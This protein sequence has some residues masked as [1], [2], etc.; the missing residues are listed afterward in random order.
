MALV[1][2]PVSCRVSDAKAMFGL[3]RATIYRWAAKGHIKIYK[4]SSMS[5]VNVSELWD[6]IQKESP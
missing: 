5:F 3:S 4:K 2:Q 1:Q 6:F